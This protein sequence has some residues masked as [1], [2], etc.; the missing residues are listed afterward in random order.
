MADIVPVCWPRLKQS[1]VQYWFMTQFDNV[2]SEFMKSLRQGMGFSRW[3][4]LTSCHSRPAAWR[5]FQVSSAFVC[6]QF[7]LPQYYMN[8]K[9][10][11]RLLSLSY[12]AGEFIPFWG[13][14]SCVICYKVLGDP[15]PPVTE[16]LYSF[17]TRPNWAKETPVE[18][19]EFRWLISTDS[20]TLNL[21][22]TLQTFKTWIPAF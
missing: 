7:L 15:K 17:I 6:T 11:Q 13:V 9:P 20:A 22:Q 2:S 14:V 16:K 12:L 19:L 10:L 3:P 5:A 18:Y 4:N 8:T 21:N 1:I